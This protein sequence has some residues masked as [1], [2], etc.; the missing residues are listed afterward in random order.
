MAIT[1]KAKILPCDQPAQSGDYI[2][3]SVLESYVNSPQCKERLEK[4]LITG[5]MTH[6]SRK[7]STE[8]IP[9]ADQILMDGNMFFKATRLWM[10]GNFLMAE[11]KVFE[12]LKFNG[13]MQT[14]YDTFITMLKNG[15]RP[16]V[17]SCIRAYWDS[18]ICRE[19]E[20]LRGVDI[21]SVY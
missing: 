3:R 14:A 16:P 9:N 6:A 2:P 13:D 11:F 12:D 20:F 4:G 5:G 8:G 7:T 18:N 10:Q 15:I 19:I 21:S 17:S 1:F